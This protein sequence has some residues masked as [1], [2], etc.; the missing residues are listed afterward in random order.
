M[1]F[2]YPI[3]NI[4][5]H[6][7]NLSVFAFGF[8]SLLIS[9]GYALGPVLLLLASIYWLARRPRICLNGEDL[10]ILAALVLY[11]V[12]AILFYFY[13][14]EEM[15]QLDGAGRFV[16]AVLVLLFLLHNPFDAR[17]FWLGLALG[18]I[19]VGLISIYLKSTLDLPRVYTS[20]IGSLQLGNIS[21]TFAMLN[22]A[23]IVWAAYQRRRVFWL[24]LMTLAICLGMV[25]SFLAGT[26]GAWVGIPVL[27]P[28]L[29]WLYWRYLSPRFALLAIVLLSVLVAV[30]VLHPATGVR[31]RFAVATQDMEQLLTHGNPNTSIGRRLEMWRAGLMAFSE[32]PWLGWGERGYKEF[33]SGKIEEGKLHHSIAPHKSLHNQFIEEM[34]KRGLIGLAAFLL[35]MFVPLILFLRKLS[36]DDYRIRVFGAAGAVL[37]VS[38]TVFHLS[39]TFF[40]R[41]NATVVFAFLLVCI[42]AAVR[43]RENELAVDAAREGDASIVVS[44]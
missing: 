44:H 4:R 22:A 2:P 8:L 21:M 16:F 38:Y 36:A 15:R 12:V 25:S 1:N 20:Y 18:S 32:K 10:A 17:Y 30:M 3:E 9:D 26:R 7:I 13:H 37:M 33:E 27:M 39:L 6:Y 5:Q 42:W 11:V 28:V 40:Y 41:N 35:L 31:E 14:D 34:A 23:G 24:V 43:A 29:A 19:G